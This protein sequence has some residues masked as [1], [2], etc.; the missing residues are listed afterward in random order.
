M[1]L[2][3]Q[4]DFS[5]TRKVTSCVALYLSSECSLSPRVFGILMKD[6]YIRFLLRDWKALGAPLL[7]PF[8]FRFISFSAAHP[9]LGCRGNNLSRKI[10]TYL[11]M[12]MSTN[13]SGRTPRRS[14]ACLDIISPEYPWSAPGSPPRWAC[15]KH[16]PREMSRRHPDHSEPLPDVRAPHPIPKAEPS[17]PAKEAH[18]GHLYS[19]PHSFSHYPKLMTIVESWDIHLRGAATVELKSPKSSGSS[20]SSECVLTG[21]KSF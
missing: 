13:S 9:S 3:T 1:H 10:Q 5:P 8:M 18:F 17:H 20:Y 4:W 19:R 6:I 11:S 21:L 2:I 12:A 15:P 14:Q 7:C 16:L